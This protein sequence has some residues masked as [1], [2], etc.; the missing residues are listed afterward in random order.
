MVWD[1]A[2]GNPIG[3]SSGAWEVFVSGIASA[4]T[5]CFE[6]VNGE[7]RGSV[8]QADAGIQDLSTDKIVSTDPPYY[9]NVGYADLSDFFYVWLRRA[10]R[11]AFPD[12]FTTLAVPKAEELV[13][14]P[15][16]HGGKEVAERFFLDGMKEAIGRLA[17][18]AHPI[19][20]ITIYYAFKQSE[21]KGDGST[22]STGWETFLDA[23]IRSGFAITGTWPMRTENASRLR[24]MSSNALASSIVLV[25][26]RRSPDTPLTSRRDFLAALRSELPPALVDLQKSNIA[27]VDLAQA[28]IGP[29]MAI[30]TR[31]ARVLEADGSPMPVRSALVEINRMLDET[32]ARQEGDLDPDTR[33]CV[34]WYEQ[35]GVGER[36][37]GEAEVLFSAKNTS[38]EGLQR[39]GVIVGGK[40]KVRLR[41]RD[42]LDPDWDPETDRRI[43]DWE[44][45]Q[46]LTCSLTAERGGGVAEA[47]RLVLGMGTERAEKAR[48]LAYRLYSLAERKRWADEAHAYNILVTSWPQIQTEAARLAAGVPQQTGFG[49]PAGEAS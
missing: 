33:F 38:F 32:L 13:A 25:C 11:P 20:P 23:V 44:G 36:A 41:R 18:R 37:Y 42:E 2:E 9:D 17:E 29:G 10:L 27:P 8:V 7:S 47:A 1:F 31:Y 15:Y 24:G 19:F 22:I 28:A 48:A 21:I 49:F 3:H 6:R 43:T 5:R 30:Y 35:Y 40:G 26:R 4:F 16:R 14:T 45:A 46:H 39:A 34:A 12:L